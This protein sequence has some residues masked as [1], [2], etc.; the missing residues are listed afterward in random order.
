ME[1]PIIDNI[2]EAED[3]QGRPVPNGQVFTYEPGTTT[4]KITYSDEAGTVPNTNP[5]I[6]DASGKAQIYGN[7]EYTI[8]V[9][10]LFGSQVPGFPKNIWSKVTGADIEKMPVV[11]DNIEALRTTTGAFQNQAANVLGYFDPGD[12]GGG[13]TRIWDE[14]KAVGFYIDNGGSIIVPNG[15][16][17]S[18]AWLFNVGSFAN[19]KEFGADPSGV[20]NSTAAFV[21]TQSVAPLKIPSGTFLLSNITISK[22]WT[23]KDEAIIKPDGAATLT[24]NGAIN[25]GYY[26]I[27]EPG[28]AFNETTG[29]N[30][31]H[32]KANWFGLDRTGVADS[33]PNMQYGIDFCESTRTGE[34]RLGD[35]NYLT[36]QTLII[37]KSVSIRGLGTIETLL[38]GG[39]NITSQSPVLDFRGTTGVRIQGIIIGDMTIRDKGPNRVRGLKGTWLNLSTVKDLVLFGLELGM[40]VDDNDW[41]MTYNRV[42][43]KSCSSAVL[44]GDECANSTFND[45]VLSGLVTGVRMTSG[46]IDTLTFNGCDFEGVSGSPIS[47]KGNILRNINIVNCR[48]EKNVGPVDINPITTL[49]GLTITGSNFNNTGNNTV[50]YIVLRDVSG[51]TIKDNYFGFCTGVPLNLGAGTN[52]YLDISN[53][54]NDST[55]P[56]TARPNGSAQ[57]NA[58]SQCYNQKG[59]PSIFDANSNPNLGSETYTAGSLANDISGATNGWRCT[60]G[61]TPGTWVLR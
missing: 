10:D 45:C 18:A 53:N 46:Q 29:V 5:V 25:A 3:E 43:A 57:G 51:G 14:G 15:G 50:D 41:G 13:P 27:F 58:H 16:D 9:L 26:K 52:E 4:P 55:K 11:F 30:R 49:D 20:S 22:A 37:S 36:D 21:A 48:F 8:D 23:F 38:W 59:S 2:F 32:A 28:W 47:L 17:G 6:L 19:P 34:W 60:V 61:G 24:V 42:V 1:T 31:D 33:G 12:G 56:M 7:G 44:I 35:G 54:A 39:L 40:Q